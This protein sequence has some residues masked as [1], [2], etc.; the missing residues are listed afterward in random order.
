MRLALALAAVIAA[1]ATPALAGE[2]SGVVRDSAAQPVAGA[3][4]VLPEVG[5]STTTAA[6]GSYSFENLAAGEYRLAVEVAADV[7]QH[8]TAEV[9]ATG[10]V[11]RNIFLY[12]A[13]ALD[14]A[15]AG[16]NPVEA[17][18]LDVLAAQAWEEAREMTADAGD[19]VRWQWADD[20]G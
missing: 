3:E 9:P 6:D 1:T 13:S 4:V 16:V 10:E 8:A 20:Q 7:R 15:R 17:M 11:T 18:L 19:A 14:H 2:L 12:S 5:L